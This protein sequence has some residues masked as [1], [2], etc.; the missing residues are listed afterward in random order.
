VRP[1]PAQ[2]LRL[3]LQIDPRSGLLLIVH[4]KFNLYL[5]LAG[6]VETHPQEIPDLPIPGARVQDG[7]LLD[8]IQ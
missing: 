6:L 4:W 8:L 7:P 5:V 1:T 2:Q 3:H